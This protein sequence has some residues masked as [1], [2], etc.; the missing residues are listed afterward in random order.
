MQITYHP[1]KSC[2]N[3]HKHGMDFTDLDA[4]FTDT[5][6][7]SRQDNDH[8]EARYTLIGRGSNDAIVQ[9]CF[10]YLD[11]CDEDGDIMVRVISARP[12]NGLERRLYLG[13]EP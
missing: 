3:K 10:T 6:G 4:V 13:T 11:E 2:T 1:I 8:H 7:V 12:A 5:M 9:V